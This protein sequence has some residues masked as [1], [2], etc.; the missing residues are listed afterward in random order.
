MENLSAVL[1]RF[2]R[3]S[4]DLTVLETNRLLGEIVT[5]YRLF[6]QRRGYLSNIRINC[7]NLSTY[8]PNPMKTIELEHPMV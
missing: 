4:I 1:I 8:R 6:W 5:T 3:L 2:V 7:E